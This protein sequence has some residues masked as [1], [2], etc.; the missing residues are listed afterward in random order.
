M[1]EA[2]CFFPTH[3]G[4]QTPIMIVCRHTIGVLAQNLESSSNADKGALPYPP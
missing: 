2:R 4:N 1:L 3:V